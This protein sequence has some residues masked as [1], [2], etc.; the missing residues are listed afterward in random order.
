MA[1]RSQ[2]IVKLDCTCCAISTC[3]ST[4]FGWQFTSELKA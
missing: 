3:I 4:S 1:L 2:L